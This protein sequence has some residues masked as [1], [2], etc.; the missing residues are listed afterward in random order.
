MDG[1]LRYDEVDG[2]GLRWEEGLRLDGGLR[3]N[4]GLGLDGGL[5]SNGRL[6]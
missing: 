1:G 5:R 3:Y 4:G 2:G 6:R